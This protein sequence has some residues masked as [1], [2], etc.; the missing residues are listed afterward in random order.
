M[1][2]GDEKMTAGYLM[3][4]DIG[5]SQSKGVITDADGT[6]IA[7]HSVSHSTASVKPGYFEHDPE[8]VWFHDLKCI[9]KNLL[10]KSGLKAEQ[11]VSL[12]ISAIGPCVAV[13]DKE[14]RPLRNAILYGI[15]TRAQRQIEKMQ[16]KYSEEYLIRHCGNI[17]ST[18][19]AGP[20]ILWIRENEPDLFE[21]TEMIMTAS[22]YL[23]WRLTG[24]N[25]MDYYTACAGYTPL[26]DYE[27][28]AWDKEVCR[29]LGCEGKLPELKWTTA[30]AG[31]VTA[32]AAAETGLAEGTPVNAGTCDAAAEAVSVGVVKPG[33]TMAMLG[34]TAFLITVGDSPK[35]DVRMWAAPYLFPG[36]YAMLGG[37]NA[38]GLLIDWFVEKLGLE[39]K[40]KAE[41]S[42][43]SVYEVL[44]EEAEKTEPGA[45]G[46]LVIPYFCGERTPVFDGSARGILF[47]LTLDHGR[48]HVFRALLEGIG[49]GIRDNMEVFDEHGA[50]DNQVMA[51]GGG[52]KNQLLLR[53]ISDITG[54]D[55][56]VSEVTLGAAYGDAFLAGIAAGRV[57]DPEEIEHWLRKK[58]VIRPEK[59][60]KEMYDS[61]FDIYRK[62]YENTKDLMKSIDGRKVHEKT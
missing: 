48:G 15:D 20:K 56:T 34:S 57:D 7:F 54:K 52:C 49:Y 21:R 1:F 47:G 4:I 53:V 10:G 36:S 25:V 30:V 55:L 60:V 58:C 62:L 26:F 27:T 44:I 38:A 3:G 51:V 19:S 11:I 61:G 42:G 37:M 33:R 22:S 8:K 9:V 17:L 39:V 43:R 41:A 46:M 5:T 16:E 59:E 13:T 14:G 12:G 40:K 28:M 24:K 29:E 2:S 6:M 31:N 23:I 45:A 35:S 50:A 18:Q 32:E